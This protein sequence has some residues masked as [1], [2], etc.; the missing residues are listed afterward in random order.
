VELAQKYDVSIHRVKTAALLHDYAKCFSINELKDYIQTFNLP[1]ELLSFHHE[2]WHGPVAAE[3]VKE[4]FS[5]MDEEI[6]NA[7]RYHTTGRVGMTT[8]EY[9]IFV[10]DYIEPA[11]SFPGIEEVRLM[12]KVNVESAA[13]KALRN[14]II[15][16]MNQ[17]Q[18]VHPDSYM[19]Y[20]H[21]TVKTK[22]R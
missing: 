13:R 14:T 12:A 2:L 21:L 4:R 8:L 20:N 11:R 3:L 1:T 5:I 9:I 10:A 22:E 16:L 17:D 6:L 15:F 19:A 7:I 18:A